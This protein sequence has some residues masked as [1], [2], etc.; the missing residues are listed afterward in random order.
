[1]VPVYNSLS[2]ERRRSDGKG[3]ND[4]GE[5]S[6]TVLLKRPWLYDNKPR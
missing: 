4:D 2:S 1:M 3:K 6:P 5:A